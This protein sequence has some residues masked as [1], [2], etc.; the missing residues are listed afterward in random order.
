MQRHKAI[1]TGAMESLNDAAV[2]VAPPPSV[3]ATPPDAEELHAAQ[4]EIQS[5]VA[6]CD[7][8]ED[9]T[10]GFEELYEALDTVMED[11][12][13]HPQT[14]AFVQ[15]AINQN[16]RL[17]GGEDAAPAMESGAP[18]MVRTRMAMESI[19]DK[20]K[21]MIDAMIVFVKRVWTMVV[22]FFRNMFTRSGKIRKRA[23]QALSVVET[24]LKNQPLPSA[25]KIDMGPNANFFHFDGL[26]GI[27]SP[28]IFLEKITAMG[29]KCAERGMAVSKTFTEAAIGWTS[30]MSQAENGKNNIM[31][32]F[33]KMDADHTG[34]DKT[35]FT[36]EGA[37]RTVEGV[38][39][40]KY[41]S[42]VLPGNYVLEIERPEGNPA[43]D[44]AADVESWL[45]AVNMVGR[46]RWSYTRRDAKHG[47]APEVE[48]LG[49]QRL[50]ELLITIIHACD[51]FDKITH[52]ANAQAKSN[53][54][55]LK[56]FMPWKGQ[57]E[58]LHL[59]G[60]EG[61]LVMASTRAYM[62][63]QRNYMQPAMVLYSYMLVAAGM[64]MHY[65]ESCLKLYKPA[66][67]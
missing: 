13:L 10:R 67:A 54:E 47:T 46:E 49:L 42:P 57:L 51:N 11:G 8:V 2:L 1:I 38:Q 43:A 64:Y 31:V 32:G 45:K 41:A 44:N 25:K 5:E 4:Q 26:N 36:V 6:A 3:D 16:N 17:M 48:V 28:I 37:P 9:L 18:P 60:T 20:I 58:R 15:L 30:K 7:H 35:W 34:I 65:A 56:T 40:Q 39:L 53:D 33:P 61:K 52:E 50:E 24:L 19:G 59:G 22:E 63:V 66:A 55:R 14:D 21:E 23:T 27:S 12:G 62:R 29:V